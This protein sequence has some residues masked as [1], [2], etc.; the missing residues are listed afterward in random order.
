[1]LKRLID[2]C[3]STVAL[4]VL[5]PLLAII[6]LLVRIDSPGPALFRQE[7]IGKGR[8]QFTVFKFRTMHH[9][10]DDR[11]H[12]EAFERVANGVRT[13][14][15]N[16]KQVFKSNEDPR[17]TRLGKFLRTSCVD[18]LPQLFNILRGE[19]S[20]VGP[21]PALEWELTYY[22]DWHLRR[23]DVKPGLTGPWQVHR[24]EAENLDDMLRMDVEYSDSPSVWQDIRLIAL[25]VPAIVRERGGF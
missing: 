17:I 24:A 1:M 20:I 5:L 9:N 22:Q 8:K 21:R 16:G 6:A 25:T 3:L 19:M 10:V 18:E 4:I 15:S 11:L 13:K 23:F 12:R 14:M 7:R 2:V